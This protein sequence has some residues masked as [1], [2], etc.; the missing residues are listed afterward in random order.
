M[1]SE[2]NTVHKADE[3]AAFLHAAASREAKIAISDSSIAQIR[4]KT[5]NLPEAQQNKLLF[6]VFDMLLGKTKLSG[7]LST[8]AVALIR[9]K[10][11][12]KEKATGRPERRPTQTKA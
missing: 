6:E 11:K 12:V 4:T 2:R 8:T 5:S 9:E 3:R 1:A 7:D 10:C